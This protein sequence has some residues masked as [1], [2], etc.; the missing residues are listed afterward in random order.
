[1]GIIKLTKGLMFVLLILGL[2]GV[3]V[4]PAGTADTFKMLGGLTM[5]A[6]SKGG[7]FFTQLGKVI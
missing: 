4:D 2:L 1:M 5:D 6:A 7:E 3:M